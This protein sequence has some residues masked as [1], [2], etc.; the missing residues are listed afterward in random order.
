MASRTF[1]GRPTPQT[2][3]HLHHALQ[4][5]GPRPRRRLFGRACSVCFDATSRRGSKCPR[6][7]W[8]S[9]RWV[10]EST[11]PWSPPWTQR[12]LR[13]CAAVR[14]TKHA[15]A[16]WRLT[17][18][19]T[20]AV[21]LES[22]RPVLQPHAK[23]PVPT[24]VPGATSAT[25]QKRFRAVWVRRQLAW[26]CVAHELFVSGR[27][28]IPNNVVPAWRHSWRQ[29]A[30]EIGAGHGAFRPVLELERKRHRTEGEGEATSSATS[31]A[32]STSRLGVGCQ[33]QLPS[34]MRSS[35]SAREAGFWN[36]RQR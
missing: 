1:Q 32:T 17:H 19:N 4:I 14:C 22:E 26:A 27:L 35:A 11:I 10:Q 21:A 9:P 33:R 34:C 15:A 36:R 8:P 18:L 31:G 30:H 20:I 6:T 24:P 7:A 16:N 3:R 29:R 13:M 23:V 12:L 2:V 25:V 5:A 28:T